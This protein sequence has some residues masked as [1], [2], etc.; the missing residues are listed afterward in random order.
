MRKSNLLF[1]A[2]VILPI[3]VLNGCLSVPGSP[4]PRFYMP[5]SASSEQALEK[6]EITPGVIVAVGPIGI[7]AYL[8]RPQ[9]VTKNK[10]GTFNFAQFDRWLEPLDSGL[11]RLINEDLTRLLPQASFQLFPCSFAIPLDYQVIV[12][13]VKLDSELDKEMN[14]TAQWSIIEAKSRKLLLT[15]RSQFSQPINPHNY[16]GLSK[17]LGSVCF[18]LS[19]EIAQD[20]SGISKAVQTGTKAVQ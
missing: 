18:S 17:A 12:E 5:V 6:F 2:A 13:V 16:F 7:P 15:K 14:F 1:C 4:N 20:L 11:A 19:R 8:D 10:D 3:L 9:M